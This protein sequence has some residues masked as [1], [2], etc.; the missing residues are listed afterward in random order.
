[1]G[2]AVWVQCSR[3][4]NLTRVKSKDA[5]ISDDDLY[6]EPIYCPRCRDGTKHLVI[7]EHKEDI[8]LYGDGFLDERY[9]IY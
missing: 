1:M 4:G 5:S 8:V 9:F 3:C 2:D 7:G 6:T